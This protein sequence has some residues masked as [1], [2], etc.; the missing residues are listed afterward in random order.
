MAEMQIAPGL[1][2]RRIADPGRVG[3]TTGRCRELAGKKRL[4][5]QF[6]D[7]SEFIATD[8]IEVVDNEEDFQDQIGRGRFGRARN[9]RQTLTFFRL[10]GRLANVIYSMQTTN[11]DF[12][13]Y[14]FKPVLKLL[15]SPTNGILIADEVGLGKTIEAGLIWTELRARFDA[16]RLLVV[17]PAMLREKWQEELRERFGVS[18]QLVDASHLRRVLR[19]S[20]GGTERGFALIASMQGVRPNRGWDVAEEEDTLGPGSRLAR[21]LQDAAYKEDLIDLLIIDEAHYLRNPETLTARVGTLLRRVAANVVLLSAT[22]IHLRNDDLY[23]LLHLVDEDTFDSSHD[24]MRI[25]E[26]NEPLIEARDLVLRG[27]PAPERVVELLELAARHELLSESR[28]LR[29]LL[30]SPLDDQVLSDRAKRRAIANRLEGANLWSHVYTRTRKRDVM[31]RRVVRDPRKEAVQLTSLERA[32]Y[33]RVTEI[34]RNYAQKA[35]VPTG[36]LY[37]TPQRQMASSMPA[38]LKGWLSRRVPLYAEVAED[39]GEQVESNKS[40]PG[41]VPPLIGELVTRLAGEFNV[42]D[43][44]ASDTKYGR[45]SMVLRRFLTDHEQ[46]KVVIFAYFR[47]T[48]DYLNERLAEDGIPSIVLKGG[49]GLDKQEVIRAFRKPGGP[50]VLLSSEVGSEGI[51]LQFCHVLVN[52]DLP[53]NPMRVEQRIGRLDRIGQESDRI[54]IW[55]LFAA[56]TIDE[57]IHDRLYER[58]DLFKRALGDLEAV[59]GEPIRRLTV[60][61]LS[62]SLSDEERDEM[63]DQT[64]RALVNRRQEEEAL[65]EDAAGLIAHGDYILNEIEAARELQRRISE[66]DLEAYV[67]DFLEA[68]YPGCRWR[69][70]EVGLYEVALTIN[71]RADLEV[72]V[73]REDLRGFTSLTLGSKRGARCRFENRTASARPGGIE[74]VSQFHPLVRWISHELAKQGSSLRVSAAILNQSELSGVA[75]GDYAFLVDLWDIQAVKDVEKLHFEVEAIGNRKSLREDLAEQL[76]VTASRG[77]RDWATAGEDVDLDGLGRSIESC[78]AA[79]EEKHEDFVTSLSEENLD[80]A[81]VQLQNLSRHLRGQM[82]KLIDIR[83]GHEV[84]GRRSLVRA[85]DGRIQALKDRVELRRRRIEMRKSLVPQRREIALGII[86]VEDEEA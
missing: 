29:G 73:D 62:K 17:C 38:A 46:E 41:D 32:F 63:I 82:R 40:P 56:E 60:D 44:R 67:R 53:W 51:D 42:E 80:R 33:D 1:R 68:N 14:Q 7:R 86:R 76:V 77:G 74:S 27:R 50:R 61:L 84:A 83:E 75:V 4:Q 36:F 3:V 66:E 25:V 18:A 35:A 9:L 69:S 43:L 57:R 5:V 21:Y 34:V 47:A 49:E 30:E 20:A 24:F 28:Q 11:T 54:S 85:T 31:E 45:L 58:L 22:P 79:A 26:A 37:V 72:F 48:L 15:S 19:E 59:L 64:A 71:A 55:N 2:V 13:A 81:D 16:R 8:Q 6:P 78:L 10:S 23:Q 39:M 65:E 12:Y 52:Y 70:E